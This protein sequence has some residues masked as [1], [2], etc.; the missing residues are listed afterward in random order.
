MRKI[1]VGAMISLDGVMQAPGG[2]TE[3]PTHGFKFGG[4]VMPLFDQE[5]G[6]ELDRLF[7]NP[8]D[9]LLG[10][11][12][13]EIF[14]AYW[15]YYD[16]NAPDGG[17][18]KQFNRIKKYAVSRSGEVDTGWQYSVLLRDIADVKRL[19]EEDGPDL[20]TQ[21][22]TE[23]VHALLANDLVDAMSI[24]TAPVVLGGGKKLFTDGSAPHSYKLTRSRVSS[25]GMM[26]AHYERAGDIKTHGA[27]LDSP[28]DRERKRQERM[29]REG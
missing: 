27:E 1:I 18:A 29:K 21:G 3:D 6:E 28:S 23:L 7:G 16:E 4:W 9:L 8:F 20:V 10:R 26:I 24:F 12:T 14:A 2:P 15:P 17:I 5:F 11:K 19:R 13:Y 25:T 22:S